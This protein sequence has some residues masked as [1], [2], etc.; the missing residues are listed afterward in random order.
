MQPAI[1]LVI[2]ISLFFSELHVKPVLFEKVL[3]DEDGSHCFYNYRDS[4]ATHVELDVQIQ[5]ED[6]VLV[7]RLFL[8]DTTGSHPVAVLMHGGGG[9]TE[10]LRATPFYFGP[11]LAHCG[12]AALAYDKRGTGD[13]GGDYRASTMDDFV[14][15]AGN[16]ANFL[17]EQKGVDAKRVGIVG[18]SQGG[19]LAPVVAVRY[20]KVSYAVSVSGPLTSVAATRLYALEKNFEE[21]GVS[22][23]VLK[24]VMPLW[25]SHFDAIEAQDEDA[26]SKL[27][28]ELE[29]QAGNF[30]SSLLPPF[31]DNLPRTGI[32]NSIGRDYVTELDQLSVPWFSLYG[33]EDIV[34]PVEESVAILHERM[35]SADHSGYEVKIIPG[36]NHS[37]VNP[38]TQEFMRFESI[39]V[40]WMLEKI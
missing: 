25:K 13:S 12:I 10:M 21:A 1:W 32:Y 8:P 19:R 15:D 30:H 14:T 5:S 31:R 34:V 24:Q 23:S 28:L 11:R 20:P 27:D 6:I 22:E 18:F 7:G 4:L 38:E 29:K 17:A 39:V 2:S 36:V 9:N 33:A 26:L 37:F 3:P 16:V 35:K 40:D